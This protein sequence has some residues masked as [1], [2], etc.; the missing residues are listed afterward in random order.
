MILPAV[1]NMLLLESILIYM[2][3]YQKMLTPGNLAA[4]PALQ[5]PQAFDLV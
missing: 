2:K 5:Q 3:I 1:C 4:S